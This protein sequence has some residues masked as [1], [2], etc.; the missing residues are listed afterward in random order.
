MKCGGQPVEVCPDLHTVKGIA[1]GKKRN[2][3]GNTGVDYVQSVCNSP[4]QWNASDANNQTNSTTSSTR[5]SSLF[6]SV[7]LPLSLPSLSSSHL[8]LRAAWSWRTILM[9]SNTRHWASAEHFGKPWGKTRVAMATITDVAKRK[10]MSVCGAEASH[11]S[12][13]EEQMSLLPPFGRHFWDIYIWGEESSLRAV[14]A[15]WLPAVSC[16]LPL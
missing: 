3:S 2:L 12:L 14:A 4:N 9:T 10:S 11:S 7:Y 6:L 1:G 13:L 8:T 5:I 16:I 15:S